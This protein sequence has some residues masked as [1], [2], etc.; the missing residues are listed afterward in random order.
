[1]RTAALALAASAVALAAAPARAAS[2]Y[3]EIAALVKADAFAEADDDWRRRIAMRTSECGRFG[4]G[5]SRRIDILVDRYNALAEA[6][7]AGDENAA[8]AAGERFA[9]A[10]NANAR[11]EKCWRELARRGGVPSRLARAF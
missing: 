2:S 8:M 5:D 11:F 3:E 10:A 1:M 6:V 9:A 4:D 7:A